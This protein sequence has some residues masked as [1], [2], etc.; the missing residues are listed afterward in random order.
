MSKYLRK[1]LVEALAGNQAL[2]VLGSG[3]T[4]AA[5]SDAAV[6]GWHG[7]IGHGL[8]RACDLRPDLPPSWLNDGRKLLR[9]KSVSDLIVAAQRV[10]EALRGIPGNH[11]AKWLR[12]SI[13]TLE[14]TNPGI[15]QAIADLQ[16]PI[17]TTNYDTLIDD[18]TSAPSI[19]WKES[20]EVQAA[21]RSELKVVVHL[22]GHWRNP[23][24]VVFGYESYGHAI[25]DVPSQA[26]VRAIASINSIVFIGTG[27]GIADPNFSAI[28]TW[29]NESLPGNRYPPTIL[30][31]EVDARRQY[32]DLTDRGFNILP[33]GIEYSDLELFLADLAKDI[34]GSPPSTSAT[35]ALGWD[36][37]QLYLNRLHTRIRREFIPDLVLAMS[38]PGSIAPAYCWSLDPEDV[39]LLTAVTFPKRSVGDGRFTQF[40]DCAAK[41][42]WIHHESRKWHVFLPDVLKY[43]PVASKILLFDDRVIGGRVQEAVAALLEAQGYVVKRA[44]VIAHPDAVSKLDFYEIKTEDDFLLPWGGKYGRSPVPRI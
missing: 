42:G 20:P 33:Y 9:S 27:F 40:R 34:A 32:K 17:A 7:L 35:K 39:P 25:G 2:L 30:L 3:V 5:T 16:A 19:T 18:Y 12:D 6:A 1:E 36:E 8:E 4:L 23:D 31:R 10:T 41:A 29:L 15:L 24:S 21:F 26:L 22:H 38:G 44:A 11:Y 13:G 37:M 28:M 14:I 43:M